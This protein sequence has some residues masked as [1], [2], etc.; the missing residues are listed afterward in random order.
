MPYS[1]ATACKFD[2]IQD[3]LNVVAADPQLEAA[4]I[5]TLST[6]Y[7]GTTE[8][9]FDRYLKVGL[10][11]AVKRRFEP[12]CKFDT[13]SLSTAMEAST[14]LSSGLFWRPP[15]GTQQ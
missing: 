13:L 12:G 8:P 11:G 10:I 15:L 14:N 5:N 3:Y 7:L 6:T 1:R 9:M 2:P 4:D